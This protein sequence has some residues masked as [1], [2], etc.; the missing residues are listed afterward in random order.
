MSKLFNSSVW[1]QYGYALA[2][3][4][5]GLF[6][7][8]GTLGFIDPF[9]THQIAL[10]NTG[11]LGNILIWIGQKLSWLILFFVGFSGLLLCLDQAT[12]TASAKA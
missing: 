11:A 9:K 4:T 8:A 7:L 5:S 12:R 2:F 1:Q 10:G 3:L 6:A